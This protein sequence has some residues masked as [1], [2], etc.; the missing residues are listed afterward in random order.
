MKSNFLSKIKVNK[1]NF[2]KYSKNLN[3]FEG[4]DKENIS[5]S[6][7]NHNFRLIFDKTY[8]LSD[9][10]YESKGSVEELSFKLKSPYKSQILKQ[11]IKNLEFKELDVSLDLNSKNKNN[12]NINDKNPI[13]LII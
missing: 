6:T 9:Y 13:V 8:K 7:L 5:L 1:Q 2:K 12:M 10:S 3:K 4:I 11:E